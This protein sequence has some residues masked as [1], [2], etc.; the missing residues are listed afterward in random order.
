[1]TGAV[2]LLLPYPPSVNTL[3]RTWNGR[4]LL[5]A[6]GRT[7]RQAVLLAVLAQ[8]GSGVPRLAGRLA[9]E[10]YLTMPD[11]RIRDLDNCAKA[12]L[13]GLTHAGLW[14]DDSQIDRL[15]V[16]RGPVAPPGRLAVTITAAPGPR[17]TT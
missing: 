5:S 15:T 3:W 2:H 11:K 10:L 14:T 13:D 6:K 7:Y 9:V 12:G 16:I 8:R 4:T 17:D 1:M